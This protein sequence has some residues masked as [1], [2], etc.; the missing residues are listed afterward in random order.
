MTK[1]INKTW[2]WFI[3]KVFLFTTTKGLTNDHSGQLKICF[4]ALQIAENDRLDWRWRWR[5]V[6]ILPAY[7]SATC[8]FLIFYLTWKTRS[9]EKNFKEKNHNQIPIDALMKQSLAASVNK[10][11]KFVT[12]KWCRSQLEL[13]MHTISFVELSCNLKISKFQAHKS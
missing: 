1:S 4:V 13:L 12:F 9:N 6:R 2:C 3:H 8:I 5:R 7:F 11:W 10:K